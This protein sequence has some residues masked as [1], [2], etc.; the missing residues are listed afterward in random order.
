MQ[1]SRMPAVLTLSALAAGAAACGS[2]GGGMNTST[3]AAF[4]STETA[5]V[6]STLIGCFKVDASMA[7]AIE[8]GLQNEAS[9][10]EARIAAGKVRFDPAQASACAA[11]LQGEG[12]YAESLPLPASCVQTFVG[13]VTPGGSCTSDTECAGGSCS[14]TS[15]CAGSC[16]VSAGL[17]ASCASAFCGAGLT[18][19]AA[20]TT[21]VPFAPSATG[22]ACGP[23]DF[24]CQGGLYC[25]TSTLTCVPLQGNGASCATHQRC[26]PGLVCAG[27]A[28][29]C[30]PVVPRGGA[31]SVTSAPCADGLLCVA[32]VCTPP[33]A[34]GAACSSSSSPGCLPTDYCDATGHCADRL[35]DGAG[36]LAGAQCQSG[37]CTGG[38][39]AP[40]YCTP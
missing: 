31:C 2:S 29:T 38:A 26:L 20:T 8:W 24:P 40:S 1:R 5:L 28:A 3:P 30:Q 27:S 12:C 9:A 22:G 35:A 17:G 13:Q 25:D 39:C 32:G 4:Y 21:C 7:P 23:G 33:L 6:E 11:A 15:T 10:M 19:S 18:C 34:T 16:V 37:T 36:C 14:N